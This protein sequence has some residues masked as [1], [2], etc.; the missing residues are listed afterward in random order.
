VAIHM[1]DGSWV[2]VETKN[3]TN[4]EM[5]SSNHFFQRKVIRQSQGQHFARRHFPKLKI[6][7]VLVNRLRPTSE[8][9]TELQRNSA[10]DKIYYLVDSPNAP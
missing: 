3:W 9:V 5:A 10:F 7:L 1:A 4:K 2:W 8:V 6:Q